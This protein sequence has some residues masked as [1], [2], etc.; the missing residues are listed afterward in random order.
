MQDRAAA[1]AGERDYRSGLTVLVHGGIGREF[2][3]VWGELPQGWHQLCVSAPDFMLLG[4]KSDFTAMRAWKLLQL[5]DDLEAGGTV[6]PNLH[7]FLNLVAFAYHVDFELVPEN[8]SPDPTYLHSDFML[9]L[10][11]AVRTALDR[12]ASI[13]PDRKSWIGVQRQTT[14]GRFD[15][16]H[17]RAVFV[18]SA[19]RAEGEVL[20]CVE[21]ASRPWWVQFGELPE[22]RWHYGIVFNV[23]EMVLGWLVRLVPVL[24]ERCPTLPGGPVAFQIRF[25]NIETL[26]QRDAEVAQAPLPPVVAVEDG[27]I[28]IDCMPGYLRSFLSPGNLGD[29][30]MIASLVRGVDSL[31]R[32]ETVSD[33]AMEEWVRSVVG[34]DSARFFKMTPSQTSEDVIYDVAA[35]P[36]PR[37][38]MPEDRARS[39][40]NLARRAGYEG[41]PGAIPSSRTGAL[42]HAAVDAAWERVRCALVGSAR[43][44]VIERSLLNYVAVRKEH[45][46]WL[47][48]TAAR[49][50]LYDAGKVMAASNERVVRRDSAGLACRVIA[51]MALCTSPHGSGSACTGTD[52][53]FLIAEVSTLMECAS[54]SDALRYGLAA[55]PPIMLPERIVRVRPVGSAGDGTC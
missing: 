3:S 54:Q 55:R 40:F 22:V 37:L 9:S 29:R 50:A 49:F 35:L 47:R 36:E 44:S 51:E 16:I 53:D 19:H 25:S 2:S 15:K 12:H 45:R 34:S 48:A 39:R 21:S 10:R 26:S 6:F 52:L 33:A 18:S 1:L 32:K 7:G 27:E 24:E 23:L 20:A 8:M 31:C 4:S 41:K 13:A 14:D 46:D 17:G 38:L 30:L 5:V 11:H 43:E 42:L 28:T